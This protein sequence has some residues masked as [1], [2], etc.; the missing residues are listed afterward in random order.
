M[1]KK[2]PMINSLDK[3]KSKRLSISTLE[4]EHSKTPRSKMTSTSKLQSWALILIDMQK[5][6]LDSE[7]WGSR[8][9]PALEANVKQL[10]QRHRNLGLPVIHVQHLSSEAQSPLR[11]NQCGAEFMEGLEPQ[12]GEPVF[13][14]SVNSAF[15]GTSLEAFLKTQNINSLI[16]AGLTSDHCVSTTA[17]MASNL[18]F[19]VFLISDCTATFDRQRMQAIYPA[20]LV[21][22]VSLASLNREFATVFATAK[23]L[24]NL[25]QKVQ[26]RPQI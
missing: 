23:D 22:E 1:N 2:H 24:E 26:F 25:L 10:L 3:G 19:Q 8:N 20:S 18:G 12:Q 14:K 21:H 6:F 16:L 7:Y 15:I 4:K 17:R 9:N 11:P 13:Q 5:G